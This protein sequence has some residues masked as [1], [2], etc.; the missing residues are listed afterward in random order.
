MLSLG[1]ENHSQAS[2]SLADDYTD[3]KKKYYGLAAF[4]FGEDSLNVFG[5]SL[6]ENN[7]TAGAIQVFKLNADMF[8]DSANVWD[9]LA[10]GFLKEGDVKKAQEN[11]EKA[12]KLDS[13]NQRAKEALKKLKDAQANPKQKLTWT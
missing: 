1:A 8:S 3:L 5:H 9:S 6:L 13:E 2:E 10:E 11:Y 7:D 12:L 4:D